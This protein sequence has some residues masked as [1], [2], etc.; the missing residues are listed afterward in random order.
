M[1]SQHEGLKKFEEYQ[2]ELKKISKK[3]NF[4]LIVLP[5]IIKS[6]VDAVKGKETA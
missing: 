3:M 1:D 6:M 2:K 4:E 5:T